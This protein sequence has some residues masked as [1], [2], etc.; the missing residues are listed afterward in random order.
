MNNLKGIIEQSIIDVT[1]PEQEKEI[2]PTTE[3][4]E[5]LPDGYATLSK[6]LVKGVTSNIDENIKP[7]NIRSGITILGVE[8]NLEPDKPNQSKDVTPTKEE[9]KIVADAGFELAEVNV[10]AIPS[11]YVDISDTTATE[12]SVLQGKVFYNSN[13]EK[14]IGIYE[15]PNLS[16]ATATADDILYGKTAY[17]ESGK[18]VGTYKDKLQWKCDNIKKLN[19]EFAF[20]DRDTIDEMLIGLDTSKVESMA[21]MFN[22]SKIKTI[23]LFDTSSVTTMSAMFRGYS[24]REPN[25][26]TIIPPFNTINVETFNYFAYS[27]TE[28]TTI[29]LLDL[30]NATTVKDMFVYCSKL[31]NLTLKNIKISL[32]I[33]N[34][35]SW[36]HLLTLDSLLNTIKELWNNTDNVLGGTRTLTIGSA[37]LDKLSNIYV[38][39]VT[40]TDEMRAEDE[41][42]DNKAPFEVC[43]STDEGAMLITEYVTTVKKWSLA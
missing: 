26:I 11:Q 39:L 24:V 29:E 41:Y 35:S 16:D 38:K 36:G 27:A 43:E 40:I 25:G 14:K 15:A 42:I 4:I 31:T 18:V 3:D 30:R 34:G 2:I 7:L 1:K 13:G 12:D 23:P 32:Q 10:K 28:L 17:T 19:N 5:V 37:N 33:G 22:R 9:Q 6:V 8:G 20:I 21:E